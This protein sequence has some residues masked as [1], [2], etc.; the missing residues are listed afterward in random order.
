M[1]VSAKTGIGT[2]RTLHVVGEYVTSQRSEKISCPQSVF[3]IRVE[4]PIMK[5]VT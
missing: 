1:T 3:V 4:N 5:S 2:L